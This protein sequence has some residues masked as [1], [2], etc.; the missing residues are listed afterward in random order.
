MISMLRLINPPGHRPR[1]GWKFPRYATTRRKPARRARRPLYRRNAPT[2]APVS[3]PRRRRK[4]TPARNPRTGRFLKRAATRRARTTKHVTTRKRVV[5]RGPGGRFLKRTTTRRVV[6]SKNPRKRR[7]RRVAANQGVKKMAKARRVYRVRSKRARK[8]VAALRRMGKSHATSIR[9]V[10]AAAKRS[11]RKRRKSTSPKRKAA[12]RKAAATRARKHAVRVRAAKKAARTRRRVHKAVAPRRRRRVARVAAPRRRRRRFVRV[13]T[14]R[15]KPRSR[16]RAKYGLRKSTG[17][18]RNRRTGRRHAFNRY[19][20][21]RVRRNPLNAMKSMIMDGAALYGGYIG[22][23][24]IGGLLQ[25][26]VLSKVTALATQ[27][28]IAAMIPSAAT[29]V[30]AAFAGKV[31]KNQPK[32]VSAI[33]T[34]AT[35]NL[36]ITAVKTL[37]L[38]SLGASLPPFISGALAGID[39]MGFRGYG[40]YGQIGEYVQ[41]RPGLGAYVQEA[42]AL[43]EYVQDSGMHGFDVQEALADSEV[44]GMQ[45][46]FAAGSLART[47]F[48]V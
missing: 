42:M 31:I 3:N 28:K 19:T 26:Y 5:K 7:A 45:S 14:L 40:G 47:S 22:S 16:K 27:P 4:A 36:L 30:L 43:D 41:Q 32:I 38:P 24:I 25:Q 8:H 15:T 37:V 9:M 23:K 11:K 21:K 34:G 1:R 44:Q 39:D 46:G 17:Y 33:Q 10:A 20:V 6:V 18:I 35:L 12:A 13:M 29:F 48:A 2:V